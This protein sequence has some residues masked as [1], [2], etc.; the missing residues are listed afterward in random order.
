[1]L[2]EDSPAIW[3][4]RITVTTKTE[5]QYHSWPFPDLKKYWGTETFV[6]E[7]LTLEAIKA[8]NKAKK[9]NQPFYLYMS[10]YAIHV[11]LDKDKRFYDK[12]K[13]KGMTDHE[14]AYATLIEGMDKS[15]GD[16]MDWLEKA[17]KPTTLLL[18]S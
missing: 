5:S 6:T 9:Y 4:K 10:Q 13:K 16:L 12:Y 3:E 1:M 15:L 18:S 2:P 11:P 14:A 17:E 7:A 8:L